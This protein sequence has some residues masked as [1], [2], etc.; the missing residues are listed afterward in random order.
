MPMKYSSLHLPWEKVEKGQGF[1]IPCLDTDAVRTEGLN[2]ALKHRIFN[3]KATP[4]IQDGL[5]GVLFHRAPV[6]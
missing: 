6:R 1:F 4:C 5:M 3:A 2:Q